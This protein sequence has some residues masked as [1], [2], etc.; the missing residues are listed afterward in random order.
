MIQLERLPLD[1]DQRRDWFFYL[2]TV[3]ALKNVVQFISGKAFE[4]RKIAKTISPNK[5]WVGLFGGVVVSALV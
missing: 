4:R 2:F 1:I 5:T 3:T